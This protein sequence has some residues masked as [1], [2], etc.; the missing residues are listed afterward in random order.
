MS[1]AR[2]QTAPIRYGVAFR[3][4][5]K[6][7]KERRSGLARHGIGRPY[8][9]SHP[10]PPPAQQEPPCGIGLECSTPPG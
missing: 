8:R 2:Y 5:G 6:A 1:P 3:Y 7:G 4:R 9:D 10:V